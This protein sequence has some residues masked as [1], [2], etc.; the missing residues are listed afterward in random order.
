M[1]KTVEGVYR[2]G[3]L[4]LEEPVPDTIEA[5][6]YLVFPVEDTGEQQ[7]DT[8]LTVCGLISDQDAEEML[9]AIEEGCEQIDPEGW[10]IRL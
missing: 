6:A 8:R 3:E 1:L 4:V 2:K 5:R 9:N 10:E 7:R